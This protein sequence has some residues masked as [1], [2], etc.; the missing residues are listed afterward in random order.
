MSSD[1]HLS[2]ILFFALG[3]LFVQF[4]FISYL[5]IQRSTFI[6]YYV[7][8]CEKA[9]KNEDIEFQI[10]CHA[11]SINAKQTAVDDNVYYLMFF[12]LFLLLSFTVFTCRK[13][14]LYQIHQMYKIH[15]LVY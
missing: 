8:Q 12:L 1:S 11:A 14:I 5:I 6:E 2:T 3:L 10:R 15:N 7:Q 4:C 9:K 13:K